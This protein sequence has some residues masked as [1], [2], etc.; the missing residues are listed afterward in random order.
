ML[1]SAIVGLALNFPLTMTVYAADWYQGASCVKDDCTLDECQK[2]K[3]SPADMYQGFKKMGEA[4]KLVDI[5]SERV[6]VEAGSLTWM[7]FRNVESCQKFAAEVR[8][9]A[10]ADKQK[11]NERLE[12]Y[13]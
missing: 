8:R 5:G 4:P 3:G 10:E 2:S 13:R 12:K 6:D 9:K 7:L 1:R 11:E